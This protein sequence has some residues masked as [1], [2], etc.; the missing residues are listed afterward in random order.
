MGSGTRAL[1]QRHGEFIVWLEQLLYLDIELPLQHFILVRPD[2]LWFFN[3]VR[4][5]SGASRTVARSVPMARCILT[6]EPFP[7]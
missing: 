6:F 3:K 2:L 1:S 5:P 4:P 7:K